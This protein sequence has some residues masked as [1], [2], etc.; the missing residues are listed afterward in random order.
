MHNAVGIAWVDVAALKSRP[1]AALVKTQVDAGAVDLAVVA[2]SP[3]H[4]LWRQWAAWFARETGLF[5]VAGERVTQGI[6]VF[7]DL[8]VEVVAGYEIALATRPRSRRRGAVFAEVRRVGSPERAVVIGCDL[9]ET[10]WETH[11]E[12]LRHRAPALGIDYGLPTLVTA[13]GG[14]ARRLSADEGAAAPGQSPSRDR[15]GRVVAAVWPRAA[16]NL[17]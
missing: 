7:A 6:T 8:A 14:T 13:V 4:P 17:P 16:V 3:R 1:A 2:G 11:R 15:S 9:D 12:E 5:A 10:E